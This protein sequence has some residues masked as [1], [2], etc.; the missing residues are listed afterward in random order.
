MKFSAALFSFLGL[1]SAACHHNTDLY[2]RQT[3]SVSYSYTGETGPE[4]WGTLAAE[5]ALCSDGTQQSPI[6][7]QKSSA[8]PG[9]NLLQLTGPTKEIAT[10]ENIKDTLQVSGSNVTL[11]TAANKDS[12]PNAPDAPKHTLAQFHFHTPS[13]HIID[14]E[15]KP[16][17]VHFVFQ[18]EQARLTVVGIMIDVASGN[19]RPSTFL[20]NAFVNVDQVT[21]NGLKAPTGNLDYTEIKNL[22]QGGIMQYAGSLTTPPCAEG[23]AWNVASQN[24]FV[25]QATYDKVRS[26]MKFNARPIQGTQTVAAAKPTGY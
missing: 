23:V 17:E 26:I 9:C 7:L 3:P 16:L 14:G 6:A 22:L 13:E 4:N 24:L 19:Q 12:R 10:L 21:T 1:A 5:F 25:S 20:E 11:A 2:R 18:D 15:S 8:K